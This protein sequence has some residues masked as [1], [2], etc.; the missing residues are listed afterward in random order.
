MKRFFSL[1]FGAIAICTLAQAQ[2]VI[3]ETHF[4]NVNGVGGNDGIWSEANQDIPETPFQQSGWSTS[5]TYEAKQCLRIGT[6]TSNGSVTTPA[7]TQLSGTATLTFRAAAWSTKSEISTLKLS[8]TGSN[9][10]IRINSSD[11]TRYK[12]RTITLMKGQF[13]EFTVE[14]TGQADTRIIFQTVDPK[15]HPNRFFIDDIKVVLPPETLP[16]TIPTLGVGTMYTDFNYVMP[17]GLEGFVAQKTERG[18][19]FIQA[20]AEGD[21][22]PAKTPLLLRGSSATATVVKK[23]Q[24]PFKGENLLKGFS[25]TENYTAPA[26]SRVYILM[27]GSKG[28]A[29]YWAKGTGGAYATV[30]AQRCCLVLNDSDFSLG[31]NAQGFLLS[32]VLDTVSAINELHTTTT[33]QTIFDLSGRRL[34]RRTP[35]VNIVNGRKMLQP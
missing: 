18:I 4:D 7:L 25:T 13:Q 32:E 21:T 15:K 29:F 20:F 23:L 22:V 12:N 28:P 24:E 26:G 33:E 16:I 3:F 17:N 9:A 8:V 19:K 27:D 30:L 35:G 31:G 5:Y 14:L 6:G 10:G 11:N 34:N 1:F 2:Q